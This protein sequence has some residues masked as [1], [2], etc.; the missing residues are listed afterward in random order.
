MKIEFVKFVGF[1]NSDKLHLNLYVSR[2]KP[3]VYIYKRWLYID[4]VVIKLG[5]TE[6]IAK[7]EIINYS[8]K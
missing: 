1:V 7:V 8:V 3:L 4:S 2:F 6:A 5:F